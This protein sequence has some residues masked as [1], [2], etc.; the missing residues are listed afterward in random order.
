MAVAFINHGHICS[1]IM[2]KAAKINVNTLS[3]IGSKILIDVHNK[4]V[5]VNSH[6][7][8]P[9]QIAIVFD[10]RCIDLVLKNL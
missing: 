6:L 1:V 7:R 4:K 10:K 8:L 3:F 9:Y 5:N 2:G